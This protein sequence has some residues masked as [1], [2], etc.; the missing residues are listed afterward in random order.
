LPLLFLV[1]MWSDAYLLGHYTTTL[2][3]FM[4]SFLYKT[5]EGS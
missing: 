4:S 3:I 1:I 5:Y 2:F